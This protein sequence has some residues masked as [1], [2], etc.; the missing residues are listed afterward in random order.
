MREITDYQWRDY[1][2]LKK[3]HRT[4]PCDSCGEPKEPMYCCEN[5]NCPTFK[6]RLADY[7]ASCVGGDE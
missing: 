3:K 4:I 2:F 7:N 5:D 1:L 6:K